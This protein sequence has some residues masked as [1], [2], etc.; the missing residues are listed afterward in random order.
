MAVELLLLPWAMAS[1]RLPAMEKMLLSFLA[2]IQASLVMPGAAPRST[3]LSIS[4]ALV[5]LWIV[6]RLTEPASDSAEIGRASCRERVCYV[7]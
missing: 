1:D 2:V 3:V 5:R 6:F 7:V 4:R